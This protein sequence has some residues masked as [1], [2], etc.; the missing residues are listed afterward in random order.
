MI[1]FLNTHISEAIS[2]SI[3]WTLIHS[4][5]QAPL[6]ALIMS[7]F[8]RMYKDESSIV[9]Y[10]ISR[11]ALYMTLGFAAVTFAFYYISYYTN[12]CSDLFLVHLTPN[13]QYYIGPDVTNNI[14]SSGWFYNAINP[15]EGLITS[16]WLIGAVIFSFRFLGGFIETKRLTNSSRL[17]DEKY[18]MILNALKEKLDITKDVVL[19]TSTKIYSPMVLGYIKPYILM[20]FSIMNQ[21]D[22]ADVEAILVHELAHIKRNDFLHNLIHSIIEIIFYFNPAVWWIS[23]NIRSERE[24]CCDDLAVHVLGDAMQYAKTLVKIEELQQTNVLPSLAVPMARKNILLNR[25][26]RILNQPYN[27]NQFQDKLVATVAL[28]FS[29]IVIGLSSINN[30]D[31][32]L[33]PLVIEPVNKQIKTELSVEKRNHPNL[34]KKGLTFKT[35]KPKGIIQIDTL[36]KK[37]NHIQIFTDEIE[38]EIKNDVVQRL[39]LDGKKVPK[40]DY[41][42]YI[43]RD[44]DGKVV[45]IADN[46]IPCCPPPPPPPPVFTPSIPN[47]LIPP[48]PPTPPAPPKGFGMMDSDGKLKSTEELQDSYGDYFGN[49][50]EYH[51]G[52]QDYFESQR[53]NIESKLFL[54]GD[55][56]PADIFDSKFREIFKGKDLSQMIDEQDQLKLFMEDNVAK[57]KG[58]D[59]QRLPFWDDNLELRDHFINRGSNKTLSDVI[60]SS[61]WNDGFLVEGKEN[62]IELTDKYLKI[63]GEKQPTNIWRKYKAIYDKKF[64]EENYK[65]FKTTLISDKNPS[66]RKHFLKI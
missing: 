4:L 30:D 37:Q 11:A 29:C 54:E 60:I 13:W 35:K 24:N 7:F 27:R 63:N 61:L 40:E 31:P 15:N 49:V 19:A 42:K 65:S 38:V 25:V 39:K 45:K 55:S 56:I 2:A 52:V 26:C 62:T 50:E 32:L 22:T 34:I 46:E 33:M 5:W 6:I 41:E 23:A 64:G 28:C 3:T 47:G 1:E 53:K 36:P 20:P 21:L 44:E 12:G 43:E 9:R 8:L 48:A 66:K 58:I 59:E 18:E 10:R 51:K 14:E 17:I 57:W 16:C